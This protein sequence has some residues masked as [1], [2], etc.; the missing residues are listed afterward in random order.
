MLARWSSRTIDLAVQF[1]LFSASKFDE[2]VASSFRRWS[3]V[4]K[5]PSDRKHI[6]ATSPF[7]KSSCVRSP[8]SISLSRENFACPTCSR[9]C[10]NTTRFSL[11]RATAASC[12]CAE[13][14]RRAAIFLCRTWPFH[15]RNTVE[16]NGR[17]LLTRPFASTPCTRED[18]SASR[19]HSAR[20]RR[21]SKCASWYFSKWN[22][23]P[24]YRWADAACV[25]STSSSDGG[26]GD[27]TGAAN[28][29]AQMG[30]GSAKM[31]E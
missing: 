17:R 10:R 18:V 27:A 8:A 4:A 5:C 29:A 26:G 16:T 23:E 31:A 3:I 9:Q 12:F 20:H 15:A 25:P 14:A 1:F 21:A 2:Q 22:R 19:A 11:C 6:A 24:M 13:A 28:G 30:V 7:A